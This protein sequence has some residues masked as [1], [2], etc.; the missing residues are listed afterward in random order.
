MS[1]PFAPLFVL[2]NLYYLCGVNDVMIVLGSLDI[3]QLIICARYSHEHLYKILPT[4]GC[5]LTTQTRST[6]VAPSLLRTALH[7]L[8][9]LVLHI[10]YETDIRSPHVGARPRP[11][12]MALQHMLRMQAVR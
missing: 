7:T 8:P 4:Q 1:A 9:H 3:V 10:R 11:R 5:S 12:H 2:A 6:A